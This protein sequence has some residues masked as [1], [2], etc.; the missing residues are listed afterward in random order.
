[1][2]NK[3][4][5]TLIE[6]LVVIAIIGLLSSVVLASLNGARQKAQ[7]AKELSQIRQLMSVSGAYRADTG[8]LVP[9]CTVVGCTSA[10]DP[11]IQSLG[12]SGWAGPYFPGGV[13]GFKHQWGGQIGILQGDVDGDGILEN[14]IVLDDDAPMS[15]YNDDTGVIPTSVLL[16]IDVRIDDGNL[17]TGRARGDGL[18]FGSVVGEM[19][20]LF[21][22]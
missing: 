4:G 14:R 5:F 3:K 9:S 19:A 8:A 20:I 17:G 6:L 12:V 22:T 16:M 7:V 11:I 10:N 2:R 1:M 18:G 21:S 13:H 15:G